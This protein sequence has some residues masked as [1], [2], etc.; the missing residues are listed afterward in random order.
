VIDEIF[1]KYDSCPNCLNSTW[2]GTPKVSHYSSPSGG[3][4][5]PG[6]NVFVVD[7]GRARLTPEGELITEI[8]DLIVHHIANVSNGIKVAPY[9]AAIDIIGK[10]RVERKK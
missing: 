10:Y 8:G 2:H 4:V 7:Y 3:V 5:C 1:P 6:S 9:Q